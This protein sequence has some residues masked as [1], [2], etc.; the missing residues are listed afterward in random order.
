MRIGRFLQFIYVVGSLTSV[1]IHSTRPLDELAKIVGVLSD[2]TPYAQYTW[3]GTFAMAANTNYLIAPDTKIIDNLGMT[4]QT[5]GTD[6]EVPTDGLYLWT[7]ECGVDNAV[8]AN[9]DI[10][11]Q[12]SGHP[13]Q[14][15]RSQNQPPGNGHAPI[16]CCEFVQHATDFCQVLIR[17]DQA[18][19]FEGGLVTI[20]RL[21]A[22]L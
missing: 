19:T 20:H 15:V 14:S 16:I 12:I 13:Q 10:G 17:S 3:G 22:L 1:F 8:A 4:M 7:F 2:A 21:S 5:P 18:N 6:I 11:F 9:N